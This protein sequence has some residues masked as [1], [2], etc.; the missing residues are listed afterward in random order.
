M[1][2]RVVVLGAGPIG[3][4]VAML[5]AADGREVTV[6]EKDHDGPPRGGEEA[7]QAWQRAGVSQFRQLHYMQARVR[8]LLDEQL[9]AVGWGVSVEPNRQ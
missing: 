8:H 9:P 5:L 3:L 6:L 7:W 1:D 2:D 4:A